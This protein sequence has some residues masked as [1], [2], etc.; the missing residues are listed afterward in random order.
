M[1]NMTW[2][3][4]MLIQWWYDSIC[5]SYVMMWYDLIHMIG[6]GFVMILDVGDI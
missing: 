2:F 1:V 5:D 4:L 3:F 6:I